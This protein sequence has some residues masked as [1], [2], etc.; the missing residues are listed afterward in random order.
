LETETVP[1]EIERFISIDL[2]NSIKDEKSKVSLLGRKN[3]LMILELAGPT[4]E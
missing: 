1:R 4:Q 2:L 3:N